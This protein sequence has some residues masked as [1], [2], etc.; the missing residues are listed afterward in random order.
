MVGN[1]GR[2]NEE[3]NLYKY[4]QCGV[5]RLSK[6][7]DACMITSPLQ[8]I[9]VMPFMSKSGTFRCLFRQLPCR[10]R[11]HH[12]QHSTL[13]APPPTLLTCGHVLSRESRLMTTDPLLLHIEPPYST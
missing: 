5:L 11:V 13:H 12:V 2:E 9:T 8:P 6:D 4:I 3:A 7:F 10:A 1:G